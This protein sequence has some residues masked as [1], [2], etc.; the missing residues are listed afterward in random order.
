MN[1][2]IKEHIRSW[3]KYL[4]QYRKTRASINECSCTP[5]TDFLKLPSILLPS[6]PHKRYSNHL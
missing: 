3:L 6:F 1:I 2:F 5:L 4:P